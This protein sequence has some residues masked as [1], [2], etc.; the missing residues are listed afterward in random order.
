MG[1]A[2]HYHGK[3]DDPRLLPDLL[4][5]ARHLAFKRQWRHQDLDER[6][7]GVVERETS[8]DAPTAPTE[9]VAIDDRL[10]GILIHPHPDCGM[11]W[12]TFNQNGELCFYLPQLRTGHY[13]EIK[14]LFTQTHFAPLDI[15]I[16]LCEL[17]HAIQDRYFPNLQ[18]VDEGE[19]YLT[20]DPAR[21]ALRMAEA[22]A[23]MK[24][25][26]SE[27]ADDAAKDAEAK[28]AEKNA[29]TLRD[30]R[31]FELA[32][33]QVI[34]LTRLSWKHGYGISANRN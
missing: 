11:V 2:I 32:R 33:R 4:T 27:Q 29:L 24:E 17:L 28:D 20:G 3:L 1:I 21:L 12:L 26:S 10:Q 19:Y 16:S 7:I 15:H 14:D 5:A 18:V 9:T 23:T 13:A 34:A 30:K 31:R 8:P 25:E 6:I 22:N